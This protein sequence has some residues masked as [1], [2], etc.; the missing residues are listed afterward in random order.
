MIRLN[1]FED[2]AS[3]FGIAPMDWYFY[4]LIDRWSYALPIFMLL[5]ILRARSSML[6]ILVAIAIL[7]THSLI[8][9]KEYRF[10]FPASACLVVVAAMGTADLIE[11]LRTAW[12]QAAW[13]ATMATGGLW[14]LVSLSLA[15][16]TTYSKEWN[17][18]RNFI[19][20][21]FLLAESPKLCG[22]LLYDVAWWN[23]GGYAHLHRDVPFYGTRERGIENLAKLASAFDV[24]LLT[25]SSIIDLPKDYTTM[26]CWG[27]GKPKGLCILR[28]DGGC[29]RVPGLEP[30]RELPSPKAAW[31][32]ELKAE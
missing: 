12:P 31:K 8:P 30:L 9:H 29:K 28:R 18:R 6:W 25:R 1:L 32:R 27:K 16:T 5:V 23:T 24:V 13:L 17:L 22:I 20:A 15:V 26:H 3:Q 4:Q 2:V 14:I 11:R 7:L 19:K 21:G 10:I